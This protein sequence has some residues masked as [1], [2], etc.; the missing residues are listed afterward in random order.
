MLLAKP[1]VPGEINRIDQKYIGRDGRGDMR[2]RLTVFPVSRISFN[3]S[4]KL[5]MEYTEQELRVLETIKEN[6]SQVRQRDLA[7]IL[8]LSLGMTNSIL[9]RLA[10]KGWLTILKVNN[11]NIRYAVTA[12]GIDE[13]TR[14]SYRYFKRTVKNVVYYR[15]L[16][17][18]LAAGV[19]KNGYDGIALVGKSD[20]DFI[21]EHACQAFDLEYVH[22]EETYKGK[23]FY[24][25]AESYIPDQAPES[26]NEGRGFLQ[27]MFLG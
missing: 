19:R 15:K 7:E 17:E 22:N 2:Q 5:T 14:R 27:K 23:I 1:R 21:V 8:G 9:K 11:R 3:N 16:I 10:K 24:L 25:Y 20:L 12:R 6:D 18:E 13:I 26:A 4:N